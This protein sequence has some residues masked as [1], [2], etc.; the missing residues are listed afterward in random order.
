[1]RR[2]ACHSEELRFGR[3]TRNPPVPA[4]S[5]RIPRDPSS[6]VPRNRPRQG[7]S[8]CTRPDWPLADVDGA[9]KGLH[10]DAGAAGAGREREL[11]LGR[12]P[13]RLLGGRAELVRDR[14]AEGGHRELRA[15]AGGE[16]EVHRAA[17]RFDRERGL[18]GEPRLELD[19]PRNRLERRPVERAA[20]D[21]QLAV[22]GRRLELARR[23]AD[24]HRAVDGLGLE[25][26]AR[27]RHVDRPVHALELDAL[28][29]PRLGDRAV[30]GLGRH[31][32]RDP[33]HRDRGREA[34]DG[35]RAAGGDE[36]LEVALD[37]HRV[38]VLGLD[39]DRGLLLGPVE[40]QLAAA[41]DGALDLH[42]GPVP[43]RH[44]D[45]AGHVLDRHL[46]V[47]GGGTLLVHR[48]L[49]E[50]PG[51]PGEDGGEDERCALHGLAPLHLK[52]WS[53]A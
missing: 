30:D 50:N 29:G 21:E 32:A 26:A 7:P 1:M 23:V 34:L 41:P 9:G 27:L 13:A 33:G 3:A 47:G 28:R 49:G 12:P 31:R 14:A 44:L 43:A 25:A 6:G 37:A 53:K 35:D 24:R 4:R 16:E 51:G 36:D 8:A 46:P 2:P 10:G 42:L 52:V 18:G 39:L 11:L 48:G 15:E 22:H 45:G 38:A 40:A 17:H 19:A 5:L 20:G